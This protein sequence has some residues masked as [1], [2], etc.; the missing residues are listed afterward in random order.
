MGVKLKIKITYEAMF[1]YADLFNLFEVK[2]CESI[3]PLGFNG[4]FQAMQ[5][6]VEEYLQFNKKLQNKCYFKIKYLTIYDKFVYLFIRK[7]VLE[8]KFQQW[9]I[10]GICFCEDWTEDA[11]EEGQIK[12][13]LDTMVENP[14]VEPDWVVTSYRFKIED[15]LEAIWDES[16]REG[17]IR[18]C[19]ELVRKL[20]D[21]QVE[22]RPRKYTAKRVREYITTKLTSSAIGDETIRTL[23]ELLEFERQRN[24]ENDIFR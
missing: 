9:N 8:D 2:N 12:A 14:K 15:L 21:K 23:N 7:G 22:D 10:V 6:E 17:Y 4:K 5:K 16:G 11:E 19:D 18:A 1:D 3:L 24:I 13:W 20:S